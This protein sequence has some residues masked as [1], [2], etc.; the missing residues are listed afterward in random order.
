MGGSAAT[1]KITGRI[2]VSEPRILCLQIP[3]TSGWTAYVD[4][5]RTPLLQADT[6]FSA[7]LIPEG[8]HDIELRYQTPGLRIGAVISAGTLLLL[9][10]FTIVYT[11]ISAV[12]SAGERRLAA[13]PEGEYMKAEEQMHKEYE[14]ETEDE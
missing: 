4:G 8:T 7:L 10:L 6:M 2:S 12:L 9:L 14:R 1:D 13:I 11:I 3:P 5:A